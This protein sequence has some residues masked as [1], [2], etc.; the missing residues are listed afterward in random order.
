MIT[1]SRAS[2]IVVSCAAYEDVVK[3]LFNRFEEIH[4]FSF[5]FDKILL[6]TDQQTAN[7]KSSLS[8][9]DEVV[10]GK[11]WGERV[12]N[13]LN[14]IETE[15]ILLLLDDY[16]PN[17]EID[18]DRLNI[19][20]NT[21]HPYDCIY[22]SSVFNQL[23][24]NDLDFLDGFAE[25]PK[26]LLYR[27]N[28]TVGLWKKNSLLKV[29]ANEDSPWEWEAFA[30]FRKLGKEMRFA[31]PKGESSKFIFIVTK[32]AELYTEEAGSKLQLLNQ[33]SIQVLY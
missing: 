24:D 9:V 15:Y 28:S 22:L 16:F 23:Q 25:L 26:N 5:K 21:D 20:L 3:I 18:F 13:A 2:L 30:G 33:V 6:A 29:L 8:G 27:V 11:Q 17:R 10:Y 12:R 4:L 7:I 1:K 32:Q 31:A 14:K 19:A